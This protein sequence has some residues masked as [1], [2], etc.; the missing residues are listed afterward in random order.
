MIRSQAEIPGLLASCF[1]L[2]MYLPV[3]VCFIVITLDFRVRHNFWNLPMCSQCV[4]CQNQRCGCPVSLVLCLIE[5]C[6]HPQAM[7]FL[8]LGLVGLHTI[9]PRSRVWNVRG[10]RAFFDWFTKHEFIYTIVQGG[11]WQQPLYSSY[12]K[13][14]IRHPHQG[15]GSQGHG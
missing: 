8:T 3:D 9:W 15:G 1:Y 4:A 10:K 7:G 11:S 13:N 12:N 14:Y 2:H 5:H 6:V